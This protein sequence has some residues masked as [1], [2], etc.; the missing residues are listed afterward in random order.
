[1]PNALMFLLLKGYAPKGG[2]VTVGRPCLLQALGQANALSN[3]RLNITM[4]APNNAAFQ[5]PL[6]QVCSYAYCLSRT[7]QSIASN[8]LHFGTVATTYLGLCSAMRI[9][10]ILTGSRFQ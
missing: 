6:P 3:D 7:V 5:T 4:L 8:V 9:S 1:M 2:Q 10:D